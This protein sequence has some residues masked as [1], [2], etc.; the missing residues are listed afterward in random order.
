MTLKFNETNILLKHDSNY[1]EEYEGFKK[2][3][4]V[5][6]LLCGSYK[7][8]NKFRILTIVYVACEGTKD[9]DNLT[10]LDN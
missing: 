3:K 2:R 7:E 6:R 8:G 4:V 9:E 1:H 10:W 5:E